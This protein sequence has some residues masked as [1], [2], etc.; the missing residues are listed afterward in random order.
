MTFQIDLYFDGP[1]VVNKFVI[2]ISD[3]CTIMLIA[4][5]PFAAAGVSC[6]VGPRISVNR[7]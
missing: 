2:K 1:W 7:S 6:L 4:K 3:L 5:P